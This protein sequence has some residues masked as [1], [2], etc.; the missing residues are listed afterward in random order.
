MSK[1]KSRFRFKCQRVPIQLAEQEVNMILT[2]FDIQIPG[3]TIDLDLFDI[4]I[5]GLTI[6]LDLID[7]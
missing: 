5:H 3:L 7:N 2:W 1:S 6:Y 4:Q